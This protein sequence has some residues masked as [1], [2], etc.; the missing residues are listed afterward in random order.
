MIFCQKAIIDVE[1]FWIH[2]LDMKLLASKPKNVMKSG[3]TEEI[4]GLPCF[5]NVYTKDEFIRPK[6]NFEFLNLLSH[7]PGAF[8]FG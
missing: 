5:S 7:S 2:D 8:R 1:L 6:P 4:N 3:E